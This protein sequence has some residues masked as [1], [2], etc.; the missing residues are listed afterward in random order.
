M[1]R[2]HNSVEKKVEGII[3]GVQALK[4]GIIGLAEAGNLGDDL[5]LIA[6]VNSIYNNFPDSE[7]KFISFGQQLDWKALCKLFD[8]PKIPQYTVSKP[9]IPLIRKNSTIF[10]DRD[11]I[12]F[13]GGGLLQ[14]SHNANRPYGWLSYLPKRGVGRPRVLATGLGLGPISPAW[15]KRLNRMGSPFDLAWY[16]DADSVS[17]AH[18]E[19]GWTGELC[20]DFIDRNFLESFQFA[21]KNED[22]PTRRLGV[23]LR[24]WPG[25][26]VE[27]L[28]AHIETVA[29]DNDCDEVL[30]FVLESNRGRGNDV[31]FSRAIKEK[32]NLRSDI[33]IYQSRELSDFMSEMA[34]I[35]IAISM[36]LHSSA[37]WAKL[38]IPMYPIFYAPKVAAFFGRSYRGLEI[39]DEIVEVPDGLESIP[40]ADK[41][42]SDGLRT[43]AGQLGSAGSRFS[44]FWRFYYQSTNLINAVMRRIK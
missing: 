36:K 35:D 38:D 2:V 11:V 8:Y 19:L 29:I 5:I 20:T 12:I 14:T 31:E 4:I 9:E 24:A 15:V 1:D 43:L 23:A 41:T 18:D 27:L 30:F 25:L 40:P 7:I 13:G 26:T 6:T 33:K 42:V 10:Q 39:I 44:I 22:S 37:I 3:L 32:I 28:A 34:T 16:R 21:Q 17:L